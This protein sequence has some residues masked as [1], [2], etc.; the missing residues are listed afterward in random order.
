MTLA[1]L[2][3]DPWQDLDAAEA[4][5]SV[6]LGSGLY[7][8]RVRGAHNLAY[9]GQTSS[10]RSRIGSLTVV[11]GSEIPYNDPHTAAPCLWVM[12]TEQSAAFEFSTCLLDGD[13]PTRKAW[14]CLVVSQHREQFGHSPI[15]NFGRMPNGWVKS[16]GNNAALKSRGGVRR[17]Y[18]D[19]AAQRPLDHACVLDRVN[20]VVSDRWA[21]LD[22]SPW[23]ALG[24]A[25]NLT[26]V[27]RIRQHAQDRL[28]YIGQGRI[29]AR[30]RSHQAKAL[31]DG[32]RQS[33]GFAGHVEA[34]WVGLDSVAGPQLLE[35]ECDLIASHFIREGAAPSVQF[36]G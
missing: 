13:A 6:T 12:R 23:G 34:S 16:S 3:W 2:R 25:P 8:V 19:D 4:R 31:V 10:L 33:A 9:V 28:V 30:L 20:P 14:E 11:Y 7:R 26:G 22:W 24:S 27:Y 18:R 5:R 15:A 36:L 17:G 21:G 32:H 1:T 35:V 29:L